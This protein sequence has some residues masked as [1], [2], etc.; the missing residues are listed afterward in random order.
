MKIKNRVKDLD[1]LLERI[2]LTHETFAA[3]IEPE[4][5]SQYHEDLVYLIKLY[6][7]RSLNI[8]KELDR[9]VDDEVRFKFDFIN[10]RFRKIYG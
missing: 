4:K 9:V 6:K 10:K 8:K 7:R 3:E 1:D 5:K 2:F